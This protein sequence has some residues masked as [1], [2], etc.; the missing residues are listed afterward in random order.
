M[1]TMLRAAI[2]ITTKP[3]HELHEDILPTTIGFYEP[4][5]D[6]LIIRW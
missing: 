2:E 3:I 6:P 5:W 4:V 1:E